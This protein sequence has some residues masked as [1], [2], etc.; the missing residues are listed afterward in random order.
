ML[1]KISSKYML[2]HTD[3]WFAFIT[4]IIDLKQLYECYIKKK[5]SYHLPSY[6]CYVCGMEWGKLILKKIKL[7]KNKLNL[8]NE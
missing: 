8:K 6:N 2:Y 1:M 7:N 3:K 5:N 4:V